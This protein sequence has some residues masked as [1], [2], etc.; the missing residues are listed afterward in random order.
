MESVCT[1]QDFEEDVG[2]PS[3]NA[4]PDFKVHGLLDPDDYYDYHN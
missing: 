3:H 1:R 4:V 2:H